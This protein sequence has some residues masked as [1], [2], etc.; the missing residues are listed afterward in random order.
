MLPA[1]AEYSDDN[2]LIAPSAALVMAEPA[3]RMRLVGNLPV[4]F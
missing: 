3:V 1:V 4:S 2:V